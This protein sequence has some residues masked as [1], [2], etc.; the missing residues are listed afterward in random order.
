M[1]ISLTNEHLIFLAIGLAIG[2]L[3]GA[4]LAYLIARL[5]HSRKLMT[6]ES[7][8]GSEISALQ[9][10]LES[11]RQRHGEQ[12]QLLQQT[13]TAFSQE[14]ENLANRIFDNKQEKFSQQSRQALSTTIDPLRNE[15]KDFSKES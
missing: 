3:V 1:N 14:F 13:K 12:L 4:C 5:S 9:A 15:I 11:D 2:A 7:N 10:Q 6:V 8:A